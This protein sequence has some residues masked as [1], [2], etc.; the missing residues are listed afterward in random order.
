MAITFY[1]QRQK[2]KV[3]IFVFLGVLLLTLSVVYF[4][5]LREASVSIPSLLGG[6][7]ESGIQIQSLN[8]DFS[9]FEKDIF[10]FLEFLPQR[11]ILMQP[12]GR[13][14]PFLPY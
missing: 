12:F 4:G 3:L 8:I 14:N 13:E 1:A 5:F 7:A 9:I 6:G 11:E 10:G 2:Q